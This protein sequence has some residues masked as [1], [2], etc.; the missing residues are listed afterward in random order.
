MHSAADW[1]LFCSR[2]FKRIYIIKVKITIYLLNVTKFTIKAN[3]W[4]NYGI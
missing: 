1:F 4:K 2:R 3:L